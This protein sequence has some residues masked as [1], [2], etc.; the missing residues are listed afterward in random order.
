MKNFF[1]DE[2][3]YDEGQKNKNKDTRWRTR[4]FL[5]ISIQE[6]KDADVNNA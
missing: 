6:K 3:I 2:A 4:H 5:L 1:M